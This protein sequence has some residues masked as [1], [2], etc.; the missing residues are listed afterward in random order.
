[1]IE[2]NISTDPHKES[3]KSVPFRKTQHVP[4]PKLTQQ[5]N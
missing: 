2:I 3:L 5:L 1:M 4:Y